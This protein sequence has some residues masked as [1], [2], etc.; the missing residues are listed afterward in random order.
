MIA[1]ISAKPVADDACYNIAAVERDTGLS[2]DTLRVWERRYGFPN[3]VRDHHDERLYSLPQLEKLRL[4]R[5]LIDYG[6]RPSKIINRSTEELSQLIAARAPA[7]SAPPEIEAIIDQLLRRD[8]E[9]FRAA[10]TQNLMRQGLLQFVTH[11]VTALNHWI[12]E[13]WLA[14]RVAIFDEHLY[15]EH[16]QN[17]LRNAILA[18]PGGGSAPRVLLTSLPGEKHRIG[19]LMVEAVLAAEGAA[20]VGLGT[21]TPVIDIKNAAPAYGVDIVAL[22][23]SSAITQ[24]AALAGLA[25]LRA[26][27]PQGIEIWAGGGALARA[28]KAADGVLLLRSFDDMRYALAR[29]RVENSRR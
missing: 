25:E 19:L 13:A 23:F 21:E 29:W 11:T 5:L 10:L 14:G 9:G 15:S 18:E 4:L 22:S 2:K 28:R 26:L 17:I 6:H 24:S 7:Q 27:L 1:E 8:V 12:G 20:C 3:P 16:I